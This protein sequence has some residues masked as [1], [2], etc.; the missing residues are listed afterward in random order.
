MGSSGTPTDRRI[1]HT[2]TL[3]LCS[4]TQKVLSALHGKGLKFS[5][6]VPGPPPLCGTYIKKGPFLV[7]ASLTDKTP[8]TVFCRAAT[9]FVLL[10]IT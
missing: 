2:H 7:I 8:K 3:P 6:Y 10:L 4:S 9:F 5:S 1:T